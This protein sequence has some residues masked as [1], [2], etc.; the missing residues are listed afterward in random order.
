MR[1]SDWSSDV[2][3]S[4]LPEQGLPFVEAAIRHDPNVSA[5]R[6]T[7]GTIYKAVGDRPAAR[8]AYASA[9]AS[10]PANAEAHNNLGLLAQAVGEWD[11]AREH[12]RAALQVDQG[13]EIGRAHV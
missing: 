6:N 4:D 13:Y 2:C 10:D 12:F 8:A 3:S 5:Y 11:A 9:V 7:L 1:I